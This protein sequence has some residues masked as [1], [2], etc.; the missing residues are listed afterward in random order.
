MS[1]MSRTPSL[2]TPFPVC[3]AG[4][5]VP[6]HVPLA[7]D[8]LEQLLAPPEPARMFRLSGGVPLL[9]T[10]GQTARFPAVAVAAQLSFHVFSGMYDLADCRVV[11]ALVL[12]QYS[13]A[14]ASSKSVPPA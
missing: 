14:F 8:P 1:G 3:H 13:E 10:A 12:F 11:G 2:G 9:G 6:W 4:L 7:A 5:G